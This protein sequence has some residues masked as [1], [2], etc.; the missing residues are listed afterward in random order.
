MKDCSIK[1]HLSGIYKIDFPNGK[2][3]IG[4]SNNI[5]RRMLEHNNDFRN[6]LPVESAIRK[7]GKIESFTL[8]EEIDENNRS[9]LID[10]EKYWIEYFNSN[11]KEVGYNLTLGGDGS[12]QGFYNGATNITK[13]KL[14]EI[15]ELLKNRTDLT[16]IEI[17]KKYNIHLTTLSKINNGKTFFQKDIE[18][19]LRKKYQKREQGLV[20]QK[21]SINILNDITKD[22]LDNV[23][24]IKQIANKYNLSVDFIR[25]I[26]SG[27]TCYRKDLNYPIRELINGKRFLN[28]EQVKEIISIL[29]TSTES[30]SII[31][32]KFNVSEKTISSINNGRIYHIK[33]EKYPIRKK[34]K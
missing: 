6:E 2:I 21:I 3:Y 34:K 33:E 10:R 23:L 29:K 1:E 31:G 26:N 19:P 25:S 11:R 20:F 30:M 18:Y 15:Y 28:E 8:L 14:Y 5:Y 13:E 9:L 16:E 4:L 12:S 27:R 32:E 7:Y 24:S 17:A 22:L